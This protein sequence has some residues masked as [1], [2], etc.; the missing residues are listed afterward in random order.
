MKEAF[1]KFENVNLT[2]DLYLD[3]TNNLKE[4]VINKLTNRRP[5][6]KVMEK[7][8]ALKNINIEFRHGDRI[9]I[10]GR[11][12]A[13]KST[14]LKVISGIYKPSSGK[15]T[16]SGNIQPLIEIGAGF[17]PEFTGRE[18]IYLNGYMLGFT[19]EQIRLK[20]NEIIEFTEL[21]EFIDVPVK[22]YSSGMAVRL[23]FTIA[24][25]IEPEILAFD[26][27]LA[28]G[29]IEFIQKAK[30]RMDSLIT[31]AKMLIIVSHDLGMIKS[32]CTKVLVFHQGQICFIGTPDEAIEFYVNRGY[33]K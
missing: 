4:Y 32:L 18:N 15:L 14:M 25:S 9:G 7:V 28:A 20:E 24:T 19:K 3:K 1:I 11:N 6:S 23:A 13:G 5:V 21:G 17:D 16:V 33:D 8:A 30:L 31:K 10:I 12:G 27:M 26:E 22:Y 2:Y 29:D